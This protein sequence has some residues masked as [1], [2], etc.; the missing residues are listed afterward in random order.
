MFL[1]FRVRLHYSLV[2]FFQGPT[3]TRD[4]LNWSYDEWRK[5]AQ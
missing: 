1:K 5:D 4:Y 3:A 2:M